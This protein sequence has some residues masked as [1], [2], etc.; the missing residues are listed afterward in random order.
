VP[1]RDGSTIAQ[2]DIQIIQRI[3]ESRFENVWIAPPQ[4]IEYG[5]FSGYC[6]KHRHTK[7]S[8]VT[9]PDMHLEQCLADKKMTGALDVQHAKATQIF[10][11]GA[12]DQQLGSWSLYLCLNGEVELN[13]NLFILNEGDWYQV[14]RDFCTLVNRHFNEVARS[15]LVL[16][17]YAGRQER[18]YLEAIAD[19]ETLFLMDRKLVK[20]EGATSSIEFC[21]L[22]T[23]DG[24]L[25]HV[26][27][28]SSSSVLS[29][30]FSQA[31]VSAETLLHSPD[32]V[33]KISALLPHGM[34]FEF[35]GSVFPRQ[36][37]V[38]LAIMQERAGD[39]HMPFFSK[40]NLRQ[41]SQRLRD[42]GF[43]VELLKIPF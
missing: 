32:L 5:D 35:D 39:L 24:H 25:V 31:Y 21:D 33:A 1:V 12:D 13:G 26:K 16:P 11:H 43:Q 34:D 2:L 10:L 28:Y 19:N 15:D 9:Y 20:P 7:S 8:Q 29:H 6:Y 17:S 14:E 30:L 40:V 23:R 41:Y 4:I 36:N 27:K 42:M 3:N 18:P 37:K 38:V 22:L